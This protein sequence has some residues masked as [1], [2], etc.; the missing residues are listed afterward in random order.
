MMLKKLNIDLAS[1][2]IDSVAILTNRIVSSSIRNNVVFDN[3][4]DFLL[5]LESIYRKDNGRR[6]KDGNS[7]FRSIS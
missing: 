7:Y 4:Q 5:S 3:I 1:E 6:E 2:N